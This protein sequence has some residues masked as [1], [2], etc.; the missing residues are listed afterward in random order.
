MSATVKYKGNTLATVNNETKTLLTAGKYMEDDVEITDVTGGGTPT[1]QTKSKSYTPTESA[2]TEQVRADAGYDG[3]DE[4]DISV[5]AISSSYVGSGVTRRDSSDLSASGAT[6][7]AP[8]GY[9]QSAASKAVASGTEGTPTATKS[10]VS[11]HAVTVTPSVTNGAGYI[12]GGTHNGTGVQ[13]AVSELVS[14]TKQITANGTG[15]D[16]TEYASVDVA[17]PGGGSSK[18]I[19][20]YIGRAE[21]AA[22]SYTATVV[23]VTISKAGTYKCAWS[24][25]RNTTSGTN[26]SRIY[27]N[28]TAVGTAHTTWTHNGASCEEELSLAANDVLVVRARSRNTSY[29]VGVSNLICIEQ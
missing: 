9:Y 27:K 5:A 22:S 7:T 16:V 10:A 2:Q 14:G 6:V 1:L 12:A 29:Y 19:Q 3:L 24:M 17:V 25:D 11:N 8:A 26:G 28:G 4:V 23:S 15:I 21:V 20:Y 18:N 13:V